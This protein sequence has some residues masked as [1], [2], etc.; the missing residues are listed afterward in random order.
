M[1]SVA[2]RMQK[3]STDGC[4]TIQRKPYCSAVAQLQRSKVLVGVE[5]RSSLNSIALG[6]RKNLN[7]SRINNVFK[8]FASKPSRMLSKDCFHFYVAR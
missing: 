5:V 8:K 3:R 1:D 4:L 6:G 2:L 7:I